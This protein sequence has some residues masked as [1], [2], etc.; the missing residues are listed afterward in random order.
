MTTA[1]DHQRLLGVDDGAT[2]NLGDYSSGVRLDE[3]HVAGRAGAN[4]PACG[5][6]AP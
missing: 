3:H 6:P 4:Q 5:R 2:T 1:V